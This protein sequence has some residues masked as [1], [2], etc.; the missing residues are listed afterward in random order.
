MC[1][2]SDPVPT[3]HHTDNPEP[4]YIV[5]YDSEEE[6]V[7]RLL[8]QCAGEL[9]A[10]FERVQVH[11]D[12]E[13]IVEENKNVFMNPPDNYTEV[14]SSLLIP[15]L[16][17]N[18]ELVKDLKRV[19][20]ALLVQWQLLMRPHMFNLSAQKVFRRRRES[21]EFFNEIE[22]LMRSKSMIG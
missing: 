15:F 11:A 7:S 14:L 4:I 10:L 5:N 21:V 1:G 2:L 22:T 8:S 3:A 6:I 20:R 16:A 9:K 19:V 12:V 13:K 17:L 18:V